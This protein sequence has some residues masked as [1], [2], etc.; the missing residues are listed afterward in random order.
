MSAPQDPS[1]RRAWAGCRFGRRNPVASLTARWT[2]RRLRN[3]W[4]GRGQASGTGRGAGGI[5]PTLRLCQVIA[6]RVPPARCADPSAGHKRDDRP[7]MLDGGASA[8]Q[9]CRK[10]GAISTS[11]PKGQSALRKEPD[12]PHPS[13]ISAV[14]HGCRR[15]APEPARGV[16]WEISHLCAPPGTGLRPR[17]SRPAPRPRRRHWPAPRGAAPRAARRDAIAGSPPR[18]GRPARPGS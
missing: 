14:G 7:A 9:G 5:S 17:A 8:Q 4:G 15:A 3:G 1:G 13:R 2:R 12:A 18:P 11:V 16:G 10:R 6:P